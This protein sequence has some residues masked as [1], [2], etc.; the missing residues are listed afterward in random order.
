MTRTEQINE[1]LTLLADAK[2]EITRRLA[3]HAEAVPNIKMPDK[4]EDPQPDEAT[5]TLYGTTM[6]AYIGEVEVVREAMDPTLTAIAGKISAL[7]GKGWDKDDDIVQAWMALAHVVQTLRHNPAKGPGALYVNPDNQMISYAAANF[8]LKEM[9]PSEKLQ[10]KHLTYTKGRAAFNICAEPAAIAKA[11]GH[12]ELATHFTLRSKASIKKRAH[13][14][15]DEL[16]NKDFISPHKMAQRRIRFLD[17]VSRKAANS[18]LFHESILITTA[19]PCYSCTQA[20][21]DV[22]VA[23]VISDKLHRHE[24]K[25]KRLT[26]ME[27]AHRTLHAHGV[28][29]RHIVYRHN[30]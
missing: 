2:E 19:D 1:I 18:K 3:P 17:R 24:M 21:I 22:G 4:A 29:H 6:M 11:V 14:G 30:I 8:W 15:R 16:R 13:A 12:A 10:R 7:G 23:V 20:V 27:Q 28:K 26:E 5:L 25:P 9:Q